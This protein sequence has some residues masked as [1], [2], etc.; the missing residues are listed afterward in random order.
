MISSLIN[1]RHV[2]IEFNVC[3]L[4]FA[5]YLW[6]F[7]ILMSLSGF[8][9]LASG[10]Q[11]SIYHGLWLVPPSYY[12]PLKRKICQRVIHCKTVLQLFRRPWIIMDNCVLQPIHFLISTN[13]YITNLHLDL[14]GM[15]WISLQCQI[16]CLDQLC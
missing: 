2:C 16:P 5:L 1:T 15:F 7:E 6:G 4:F 9:S 8:I 10:S 12:P 3:F 13:M 14:T 11:Y